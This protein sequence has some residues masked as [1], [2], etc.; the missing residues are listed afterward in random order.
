MKGVTSTAQNLLKIFGRE[1]FISVILYIYFLLPLKLVPLQL[2]GRI[3][4]VLTLF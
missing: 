3:P 1:Y 4:E 2:N